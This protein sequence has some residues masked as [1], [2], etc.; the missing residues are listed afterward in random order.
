[1][2]C[3]D[4]NVPFFEGLYFCCGWLTYLI[5]LSLIS[6]YHHCVNS[7]VRS[8]YGLIFICTGLGLKCH[9]AP[10]TLLMK[11]RY[12]SL[13]IINENIII[14]CKHN[15][16]VIKYSIKRLSGHKLYRFEQ[17]PKQRKSSYRQDFQF[18]IRRLIARSHKLVRLGLICW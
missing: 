6:L 5:Y 11:V 16:P 7:D 9:V 10:F 14:W 17:D 8:L 12:K 4:K 13:S 18:R 3:S 15:L 1:M 2:V